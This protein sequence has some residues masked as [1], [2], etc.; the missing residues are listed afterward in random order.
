MPTLAGGNTIAKPSA[1]PR[2]G[3]PP[4]KSTTTPRRRAVNDEGK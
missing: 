1:P 3:T 4:P 2:L